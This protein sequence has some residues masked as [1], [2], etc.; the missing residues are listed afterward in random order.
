MATPATPSS[1]RA[2]CPAASE[3]EMRARLTSLDDA[4]LTLLAKRLACALLLDTEDQIERDPVSA[5]SRRVDS[6]QTDSHSRPIRPSKDPR[7]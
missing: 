3:A 4:L 2:E 7:Q 6:G 5:A 1:Q